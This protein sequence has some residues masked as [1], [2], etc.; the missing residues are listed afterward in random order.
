M[1]LVLH[2]IVNTLPLS[3]HD[4][5]EELPLTLGSTSNKFTGRDLLSR[6]RIVYIY[7]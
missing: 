1:V 4:R 3:F 6:R 5:I 2:E 7:K